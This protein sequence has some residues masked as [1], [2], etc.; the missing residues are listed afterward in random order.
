MNSPSDT[1]QVGVDACNNSP[2]HRDLVVDLPQSG[3]DQVPPASDDLGSIEIWI[4]GRKYSLAALRVTLTKELE[5]ITDSFLKARLIERC[6]EARWRRKHETRTRSVLV[7]EELEAALE[8]RESICRFRHSFIKEY[9]AADARM[10]QMGDGV[11]SM[12][13]NEFRDKE[14]AHYSSDEERQQVWK[15]FLNTSKTEWRIFRDNLK[16]IEEIYGKKGK[17]KAHDI[18]IE[19]DELDTSDEYEW[20]SSDDEVLK[21]I[22]NPQGTNRSTTMSGY[23]KVTAFSKHWDFQAAIRGMGRSMNP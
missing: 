18:P 9:R 19:D 11:S 13:R 16:R 6:Q 5:T 2:D 23:E 20:D 15:E 17:E 1:G 7:K 4:K 8:V 3:L 12:L 14:L 21:A 10:T 22:K